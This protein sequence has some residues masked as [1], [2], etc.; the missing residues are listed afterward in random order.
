M[1]KAEYLV[2]V[3]WEVCN[4]VGGIYTVIES[5]VL[6]VMQ[7]Y[8]ENYLLIGPFLNQHSSLFV[9]KV[10][11][12]NLEPIFAELKKIGIICHYGKWSIFGE[13]K[14]VLIDVLNYTYMNNQIKTDLW[15][16]YKIDSLGTNYYDY[17][18]PIIW[19]NAV[20]KFIEK[21][22]QSSNKKIVGQFHEWLAASAILY[23]KKNN[24]KV[25]T[26]FTTHATMLGRTLAMNNIDIYNNIKLIDPIKEAY[27]NGIQSKVLTE[28]A[29][30]LNADVFT[31]VSE[32]TGLECQY[33]LGKKPDVL[34]PNG[35]NLDKY[36]TSE[37]AAIKHQIYRE[38]IREFLLYYF[39]PYYTFEL[40]HTLVYFISGR[41][42]FHNK[43]IDL[44]IES[45]AKL[46]EKLKS[47]KSNR[48]IIV[49]LWIPRD[50]IRIKPEI[51]ENRAFYEDIRNEIEENFSDIKHKII[52][53]LVSDNKTEIKDLFFEDSLFEINNKIKR[54][55]KPYGIPPICTHDLQNENEDSII[56]NLKS[57]NLTNKE[58]D[59]V[60]VIFYPIYLNGADRLLDLD[61][62]EAMM[63]THLGIFPSYYEP[64]GYTPL[65][66]AALGVS[67]ITTDL[68]GFGQFLNSKHA[69]HKNPGIF[70]LRMLNKSREERIEELF[71]TL[72]YF[73]SLSRQERIKNKIESKS[74]ANLVDWS[75][76][77]KHYI[78]AHD[79]AVEKVYE[80]KA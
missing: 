60:K 31:T 50:S 15:N 59:H 1:P 66:T 43:G 39:F 77:I 30:A 71:N 64:W 52:R 36:P 9:E 67:A 47:E 27:N 68:G 45:L 70:V 76:L 25:G 32:I 56:A 11:P 49:F 14:V 38:K 78:R 16:D 20:G 35:L 58:E 55:K 48:T 51:V 34:L 80:N 12:I 42:E 21:L 3:S 18:Q 74:L 4:K 17:D 79:K 75:K 28:K 63:G 61:Y 54:F 29:A 23:L 37:E 5:K 6:Q 46:N 40:D 2:E 26:V 44:L 65:E 19:G 62:R 10:P 57:H 13:P 41:Y 24:V 72:N 73:S 69:Q 7:Q 53:D 33:F 8:G 22:S